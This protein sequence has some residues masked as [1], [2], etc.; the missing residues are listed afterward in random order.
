[1]YF[2][3]IQYTDYNKLYAMA[4]YTVVAVDIQRAMFRMVQYIGENQ[5]VI[6]FGFVIEM[7]NNAIA[8]STSTI[9]TT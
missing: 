4:S 7:M 3:S 2:T 6:T 5:L 1:M 8:I 9:P